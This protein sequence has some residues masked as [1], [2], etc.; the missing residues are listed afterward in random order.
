M[1]EPICPYC[2]NTSFE[3]YNET[4]LGASS[5]LPVVRCTACAAAISVL[6]PAAAEKVLDETRIEER[7]RELGSLVLE[8]DRRLAD[9]EGRMSKMLEK[10]PVS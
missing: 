1:V 9:I 5:Q 7:M 4:I 10:Q 3:L 6:Q 2:Q 8:V